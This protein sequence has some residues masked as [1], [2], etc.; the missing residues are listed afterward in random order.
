[1]NVSSMVAQGEHAKASCV[2][3]VE[4]RLQGNAWKVRCENDGHD[5]RG[6]TYQVQRPK[7]AAGC[8]EWDAVSVE[9]MNL[10]GGKRGR[11]GSVLAYG[12]GMKRKLINYNVKRRVER[13][14]GKVVFERTYLNGGPNFPVC[15]DSWCKHILCRTHVNSAQT[16]NRC[17]HYISVGYPPCRGLPSNPW[18]R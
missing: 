12:S 7:D 8:L 1:M 18:L 11:P 14:I 6:R 10:G 15:D 13:P 9:N 3:C 4:E 2:P 17:T 5:E 16:C